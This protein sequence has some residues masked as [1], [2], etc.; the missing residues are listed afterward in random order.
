MDD[1]ELEEFKRWE[2]ERKQEQ[3]DKYG[4]D[5]SKINVKKATKKSRKLAKR[6]KIFGYTLK[7]L[8]ILLFTIVAI[9][10]LL[11]I[12]MMYSG[13]NEQMDVN[14]KKQIESHYHM[15]IKILKEE[16]DKKGGN[17]KYYIQSLAKPKLNFVAIKNYGNLNVDYDDRLIKYYFE[18]WNGKNKKYFA[19]D[20]NMENDILKYELYIDNYSNIEDAVIALAEFR[21]YCKNDDKTAFRIYSIYIKFNN[22]RIHPYTSSS[23]TLEQALE[24]ANQMCNLYKN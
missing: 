8:T 23:T 24:N 5:L 19:V 12:Y 9:G 21:D 2:Y 6:L 22:N 15:K 1:K 20:E 7:T 17:G 11:Y 3:I 4:V 16:T 10:T 14:V 18:N 13:L